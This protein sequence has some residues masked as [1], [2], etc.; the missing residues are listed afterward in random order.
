M[1]G[2]APAATRALRVLRALAA[3]PGPVHGGGARPASCGS[4]A[5]RRTTCWPRWP[6]TASSRTTPR[7]SAGAW[8]VA[9]LRDRRRLP[10]P[11]AARALG[12]PAPAPARA[13]RSPRV[14]P[15]VAHLGVLHGRETLYLLQRVARGRPL[16]VVV[17]GRRAAAGL[18]DRVGPGDAGGPAG[19]PGAGPVPVAGRPSSTARAGARRR[20]RRSTRLLARERRRGWARGGRLRRR[21]ASPRWPPRRVTVRA[22]RSRRSG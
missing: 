8:G 6:T 1:P 16:T 20:R 14:A 5:R 12:R 19:R 2:N 21:R 10:A 3:A 18:P 7:R 17:G 9:R 11:R 22:D 4:P 15:V 13:R